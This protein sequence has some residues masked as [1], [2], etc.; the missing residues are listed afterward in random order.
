MQMQV[1]FN[2]VAHTYICVYTYKY[3]HVHTTCIYKCN[4]F[5]LPIVLLC[6]RKLKEAG[7]ED[8]F[9]SVENEDHFGDASL[10]RIKESV[11]TW[12]Q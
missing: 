11:S 2:T 7:C 6:I 12:K 10:E 8:N 3:V 5:F 9:D 4:S 1:Y